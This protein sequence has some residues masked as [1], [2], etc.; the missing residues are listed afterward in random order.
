M[1]DPPFLFQILCYNKI[2]VW[3]VTNEKPTVTGADDFRKGGNMSLSEFIETLNLYG[4]PAV[5]L[6]VLAQGLT[7]ALIRLFRIKN[8]MLTNL[9]PFLF[10]IFFSCVFHLIVGGA[11]NFLAEHT[12]YDGILCGSLSTLYG[13]IWDSVKKKCAEPDAENI[14]IGQL[15]GYVQPQELTEAATEIL[16]AYAD[17]ANEKT[18]AEIILSHKTDRT[19]E[20][21]ALRL[22]RL[23]QKTINLFKEP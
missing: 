18:I 9:M 11:E 2:G 6:S 10:G 20:K 19:D 13:A 17:G 15:N 1:A 16:A 14:V 23:L 4:M 3:N 8:K 21:D 22:A 5:L 7:L 12:L